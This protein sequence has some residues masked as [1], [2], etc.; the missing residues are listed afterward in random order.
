MA[1]QALYYSKRTG[2][3]RVTHFDQLGLNSEEKLPNWKFQFAAPDNHK[4]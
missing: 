4:T 2:K 3:N 1:D